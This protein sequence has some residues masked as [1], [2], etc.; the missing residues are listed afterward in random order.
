M[1]ADVVAVAAAPPLGN[2]SNTTRL[3]HLIKP[4]VLQPHLITSCPFIGVAIIS[5]RILKNAHQFFPP[6]YFLFHPPQS[7]PN[8]GPLASRCVR[9][10][11]CH[12]RKCQRQRDMVRS[13]ISGL[14]VGDIL[15]GDYAPMLLGDRGASLDCAL[16]DSM[17]AALGSV[18][19]PGWL[20]IFART[21]RCKHCVMYA[22]LGIKL[23]SGKRWRDLHLPV[24]L[25]YYSS[26]AASNVHNY[27]SS[28]T[29]ICT[30]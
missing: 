3:M 23:G 6:F 1:T 20:A 28:F 25:P 30:H 24:V 29:G 2:L 16:W 12:T 11:L 17:T 7:P 15:P 27:S 8:G 4:P 22:Q 21:F 13:L 26:A 18:T 19:L 14:K 9:Q 5:W 10:P